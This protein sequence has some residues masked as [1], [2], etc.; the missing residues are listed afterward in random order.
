MILTYKAIGGGAY[1]Q[2]RAGK[3][4][5]KFYRRCWHLKT[6]ADGTVSK[7]RT[8]KLLTTA[9]TRQQA[10]AQVSLANP[11]LA[12]GKFIY[13]AEV[14]IAGGCQ[15]K[16]HVPHNP[17]YLTDEIRR[18]RQL[19][20]Y[21][22]NFEL[23]DLHAG[24]WHGYHRHRTA[25]IAADRAACTGHRQVDKELQTMRNI[26]NFALSQHPRQ[27]YSR[28]PF[29]AGCARYQIK[30]FIR[31]STT[32]APK[33][34]DAIH[35]LARELLGSI[36]TETAGWFT[37]FAAFSGCRISELL[38]LR[39]DAKQL[40][41][42]KF[43]GGF[44]RTIPGDSDGTQPRT[45]LQLGQRDKHGINPRV[46]VFEAFAEMLRAF[47]HWHQVRYPDSAW[48][49]PNHN[50]TAP[51]DRHVIARQ[52][53]AASRAIEQ[54]G[55]SPHGFRSY[56]SSKHRSD[57]MNDA[58]IAFLMGD[59][60][61]R[62]INDNYGETPE[63]WTGGVKLGWLPRQGEIAWKNWLP[64]KVEYGWSMKKKAKMQIANRIKSAGVAKWQTHGT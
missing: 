7:T 14:Y 47:Q 3:A 8:I 20:S 1:E 13:L 18:V 22:G 11:K 21:F 9:R 57:G 37:L 27:L 41:P 53:R 28:H 4:T 25:A 16:R 54:P 43:E 31:T 36:T 55:I 59:K 40:A 39:M 23:D 50:G 52:L 19:I 12:A 10:L 46:V 24:L 58:Q 17:K 61:V 62:L 6:A 60:T 44:L 42:E 29:A 64:A 48:Y 2:R 63:S 30:E 5:G 45:F 51:G 49:F 33:N 32:R 34:A 56:F 35:A 38:R 15:N 26:F